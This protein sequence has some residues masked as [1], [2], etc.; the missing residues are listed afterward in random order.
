[1]PKIAQNKLDHAE[2]IVNSITLSNPA[3][4]S[5]TMAIDN[6]ILSDGG[7]HAKIE[8]FEGVMYLEDTDEQ[9]P[10]V[11]LQFPETTS[12]ARQEVQVEQRVEIKNMTAFVE[13]NKWLVQKD[14]FRVTVLGETGIRVRGIARRYPVTFKK[15]IDMIGKLP[16]AGQSISLVLCTSANTPPRPQAL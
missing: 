16:G 10:F 1:V 12:Q 8:P 6:T 7:V 15:T 4:D 14:K 5:F 2:L 11:T 3:P 13:F 9:T